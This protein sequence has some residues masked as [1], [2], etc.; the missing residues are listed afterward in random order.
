[1]AI[2]WGPQGGRNVKK[3]KKGARASSTKGRDKSEDCKASPLD[4]FFAG[5]SRSYRHSGYQAWCKS[6]KG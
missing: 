4:R 2:K 5:Y 6:K 1:M 3:D